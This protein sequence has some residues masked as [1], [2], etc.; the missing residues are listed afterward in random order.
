MCHS[1]KGDPGVRALF[2]R[3]IS[4]GEW[5]GSGIIPGGSGARI[6]LK[7]SVEDGSVSRGYTPL[8]IPPEVST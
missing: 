4:A 6:P 5:D 3:Q 7:N 8:K 1:T 2:I